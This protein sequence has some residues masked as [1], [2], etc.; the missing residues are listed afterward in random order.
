MATR[1]KRNLASRVK[2]NLASNKTNWNAAKRVNKNL[3]LRIK[4]KLALRKTLVWHKTNRRNWVWNKA[5]WNL[6]RCRNLSTKMRKRSKRVHMNLTSSSYC[7]QINVNLTSIPKRAI[8][9][10]TLAE[11]LYLSL[12]ISF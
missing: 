11:L 9:S 8:L 4:V 2:M 7:I 10:L 5:N 1:V 12:F 6:I 3:D